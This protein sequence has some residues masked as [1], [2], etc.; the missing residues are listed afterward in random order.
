M[1]FTATAIVAFLAASANGFS[2]S[3]SSIGYL[4]NLSKGSGLSSFSSYSAPAPAPA[5]YAPTPSYAPAPASYSY[6]SAPAPAPASSY[7]SSFANLPVNKDVDYMKSLNTGSAMKSGSNYSGLSQTY[8]TSQ[9]FAQATYLDALTGTSSGGYSSPQ[10]WGTPA[11]PAPAP[12]PYSAPSYSAPAPASYS[13]GS[14]APAPASYSY[15]SPAPAPASYS[16]GSPA[17]APMSSDNG[18]YLSNLGK[19]APMSD[20]YSSMHQSFASATTESSYSSFGS[21]PKAPRSAFGSYLE[22]L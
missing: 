6:G 1:K 16:Y 14:P 22:N 3:M 5:S 11:A 13:Y 9:G 7:Q 20:S 15:G 8:R 21:K 19:A 18:S 4:D 17:P 10:G 2:V 12:M